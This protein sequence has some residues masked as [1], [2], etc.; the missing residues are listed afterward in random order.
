METLKIV[1]PKL[2][3]VTNI[4]S[5]LHTSLK[6][7]EKPK[8]PTYTTCNGNNVLWS[9]YDF[10]QA[11]QRTD[12]EGNTQLMQKKTPNIPR[13]PYPL[14]IISRSSFTR[15]LSERNTSLL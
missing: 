14:A 15:E 9:K 5:L 11:I 3:A 7:L 4:E 8:A 13:A 10:Q 12:Q 6:I 2:D 1:F